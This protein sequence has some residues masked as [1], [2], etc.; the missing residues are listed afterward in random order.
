MVTAGSIL[1]NANITGTAGTGNIGIY[2]RGIYAVEE[3]Q[4]DLMK[5]EGLRTEGIIIND[6]D[7]TLGN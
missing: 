2:N 1:N 4:G 7:I 6:A 5:L 3:L